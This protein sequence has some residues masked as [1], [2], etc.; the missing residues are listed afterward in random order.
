MTRTDQNKRRKE[1][2]RLKDSGLSVKEI[3]EK[4]DIKESVVYYNLKNRSKGNPSNKHKCLLA[5]VSYYSVSYLI[6][7]YKLTVDE[8]IERSKQFDSK[9]Y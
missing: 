5:G 2:S 3:A 7:R 8:A 6:S 9:R 4:L 1:I